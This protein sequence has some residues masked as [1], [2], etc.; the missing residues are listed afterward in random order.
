M[1]LIILDR[2]GVINHDRD[3][4]VKS[5][6]EFV[7]IDGSIDAIARLH[8]AG[9][10]VVVATNQSGLARGKFDLDDLE[11]MH[12]KLT[13]LVEE[14]G[15][16]LSAIFYCPHSPEDNCKC[17]KPLPGMIDAIEAEFNI[18]AE[19]FYFVGDSLRDMQ[20][21][22]TKGCKPILVK[23]GNG[24]KTLTQLADASLQ[25]DA[26]ILSLE[27]VKVVDNLAAAADVVLANDVEN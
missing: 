3:D 21:A 15:A 5:A 7:P 27:H 23:T 2:D 17:R 22:A 20:A 8:K 13:Q 10:T 16:E 4:F 9:F 6:D 26:P 19:G 1:K 25:T 18:S 11:A 12:E 14:Q 24:E